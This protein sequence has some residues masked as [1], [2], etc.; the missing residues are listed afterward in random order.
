MCLMCSSIILS[1]LGTNHVIIIYSCIRNEMYVWH[2]I[3][4]LLY[5]IVDNVLPAYNII[6]IHLEDCYYI[7]IIKTI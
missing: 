5:F 6:L 7:L 2:C 3:A 1:N 4:C